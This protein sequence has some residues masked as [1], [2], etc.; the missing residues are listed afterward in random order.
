MKFYFYFWFLLPIGV[1]GL[2][3]SCN[4][5]SDSCTDGICETNGSCFK[6]VTLTKGSNEIEEKYRCIPKA[7]LLPPGRPLICEYH[8]GRAHVFMVGC[9]DSGDLCNLDLELTLEGG[10]THSTELPDQPQDAAPLELKTEH[11]LILTLGAGVLILFSGCVIYLV[12]AGKCKKTHYPGSKLYTEVETQSCDT[13]ATTLQDL[14]TM[15][16]TGS[17]SGLPILLQRTIARQI[18]LKETIGKGRFGE[19]QRG[20]WRGE[21]VAVKI[22]HSIEE[23]SWKR[24][25]EIYQTCMLRHD[26]ILGFIAADN[27]DNGTWTQLWLVT[28]FMELGSLYDFLNKR[29]ISERQALDICLQITTGLAHLHLEIIGTQQGKPA[30]AHRDIKSKNILVRHDGVCAVGDLGLAVRYFSDG[31]YIDVPDNMRVGTKRYLAPEVLDSSISRNDF[32]CYKQGDIY[33]LGLVFWEILNRIGTVKNAEGVYQP[34]YWD[35][36]GIDPSIEE[37]RKVVC[38]DQLRPDIPEH[39]SDS[40]SPLVQSMCKIMTECWFT[41]PSARLTVLRVKKSL[42]SLMKQQ[43]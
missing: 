32:E 29:T 4:H 13:G 23:R 37:M 31:N 15:S 39:L 41:Q 8:K 5:S 14:M 2:I 28:E 16:S 12:K 36:V 10:A 42:T 38:I 3:C 24:E 27:K 7:Q 30:I 43:A 18:Q 17:G 1:T 9:C 20:E 6:S 21:E 22:F 26:N 40:T 25:V 19:V 35:S 34:P 33:A 11:V